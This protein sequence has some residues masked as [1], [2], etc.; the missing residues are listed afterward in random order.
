MI[1]S[2]QRFPEPSG[3]GKN[4]TRPGKEENRRRVLKIREIHFNVFGRLIGIVGTPGNWSSFLLGSEGKRRPANFIIPYF[5]TEEELDRYLA[6]H[7]HELAT[8]SNNDVLRVYDNEK[9]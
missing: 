1:R 2:W 6:D 5:I 9:K 3:I 4:L 7:F 8:P